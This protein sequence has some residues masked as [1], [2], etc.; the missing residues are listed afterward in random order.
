M[1]GSTRQPAFDEWLCK[2][3]PTRPTA[4]WQAFQNCDSYATVISCDSYFPLCLSGI[5]LAAPLSSGLGSWV[6]RTV[7]VDQL[8]SVLL[9]I[10]VGAPL[11]R[12]SP[13]CPPAPTI[14]LS[15]EPLEHLTRPVARPLCGGSQL[16]PRL[17]V[18]CGQAEVT[19]PLSL[20]CT[21]RS[22]ALGGPL[23]LAAVPCASGDGASLMKA[24][25]RLRGGFRSRGCGP[26]RRW[27]LRGF[28]GSAAEVRPQR[29]AGRS[30]L[31]I[32][33]VVFSR[34]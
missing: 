3:L 20:L 14:P 22:P 13:S 23:H 27:R 9:G 10:R 7:E 17:T 8:P 33:F 2:A 25:D 21:W 6:C 15:G 19:G 16:P 29:A 34:Q 12:P 24:L 32:R 31:H 1:N 28:S 18:P 11:K 26:P 30:T 4:S 5:H